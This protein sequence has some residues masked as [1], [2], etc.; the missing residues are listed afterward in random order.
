LAVDHI[1]FVNPVT[2]VAEFLGLEFDALSCV[3]ND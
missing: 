1:P 3:F 2:L